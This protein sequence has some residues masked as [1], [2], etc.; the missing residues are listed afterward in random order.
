VVAVQATQG[1]LQ[2]QTQA[3]AVAQETETELETQM[4]ET[5]VLELSF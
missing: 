5:A 1:L 4:V 2:R 3:E